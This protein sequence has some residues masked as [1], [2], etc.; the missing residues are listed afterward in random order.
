MPALRC[1]LCGR[2]PGVC[3]PW[4]HALRSNPWCQSWLCPCATLRFCGPSLH[5]KHVPALAVTEL[6]PQL[7]ETN[8]SFSWNNCAAQCPC[9]CRPR[10]PPQSPVVFDVELLLIPGL[11]L[12]DE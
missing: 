1:Q 3:V 10:V 4:L 5:R 12:D 11:D 8:K 7:Q 6:R 9:C 2:G